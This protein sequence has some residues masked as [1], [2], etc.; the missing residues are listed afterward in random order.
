MAKCE[1][2]DK[3]LAYLKEVAEKD[4]VPMIKYDPDL[5]IEVGPFQYNQ[6]WHSRGIPLIKLSMGN[7]ITIDYVVGQGFTTNGYWKASKIE[8][9]VEYINETWCEANKE[10]LARIKKRKKDIDN[11]HAS[12]EEMGAL[13]YHPNEIPPLIHNIVHRNMGLPANVSN[14]LVHCY[15]ITDDWSKNQI[16]SSTRKPNYW[17]FPKALPKDGKSNFKMLVVTVREDTNKFKLRAV[18]PVT[19]FNNPSYACYDN[20]WYVAK[21]VMRHLSKFCEKHPIVAALISDPGDD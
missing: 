4:I 7:N 10:E 20:K 8:K 6:S 18:Y 5:H 11:L 2:N 12:M 3:I 15:I 16:L 14:Q 9:I 13:H 1:I 21:N 19:H 17:N